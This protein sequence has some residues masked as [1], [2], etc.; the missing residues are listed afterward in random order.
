MGF[1]KLAKKRFS[2]RSFNTAPIEAEKIEKILTAGN[3]APTAANRQPFKILVIQTKEGLKKVEK[4]ANTYGAPLVLIICANHSQAWV[5][6]FD[7]YNLADTDA[8]IVTTHMMLAAADLDL[9]SLWIGYFNPYIL[10]QNFNIKSDLTPLNVLAI[11]Y[12]QGEDLS[13]DRHSATRK[14]LTEIVSY[15][16]FF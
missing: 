8:S 7:N 16:K 3:V 12:N 4:T 5:R 15:E 9:G 10:C 13:P 14:D 11:G 2:V 6:P 1:L